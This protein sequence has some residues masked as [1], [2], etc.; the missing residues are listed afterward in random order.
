MGYETI[1]ALDKLTKGESV[2][3]FMT[4]TGHEICTPEDAMTTCGKTGK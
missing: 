4:K 1:K 2:P 3:P